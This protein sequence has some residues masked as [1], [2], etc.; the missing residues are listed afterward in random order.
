LKIDEFIYY[1]LAL[2]GIILTRY[3]LV[4]GVVYWYF[5]TNQ[6]YLP[7]LLQSLRTWPVSWKMVRHDMEL[8]VEAAVLFGL[9]ATTIINA[10]Y[11]GSTLLYWP[12]EQY[13]WGYLCLSYGLVLIAQ[14]T[15]FYFLHRAFHHPRLFKW[16]HQGH[17]LSGDPTP[18][19]SFAFDPLEVVFQSLFLVAIVYIVPLHLSVLIAVLIT[20]TLWSVWNHLGFEVFSSSFPRHW[21]SRWFI[22]PTHH[23][24]H[25]RKYH[26]HYGLY[27]TI[28]DRCLGTHDPAYDRDFASA[29][30]RKP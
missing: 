12:I 23:A 26:C 7:K 6:Y 5:Y 4:S 1:W 17:H 18:W 20:M 19:T 27:F 10:M 25:H 15:Y 30:K 22:G 21:L 8:S 29:L 14:D 2:F 11:G 9:S 13:G 16:I 3:F 28:W 24:I